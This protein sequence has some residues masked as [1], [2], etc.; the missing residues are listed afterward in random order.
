MLKGLSCCAVGWTVSDSICYLFFWVCSLTL[1]CRCTFTAAHGKEIGWKPQY[2][3]EHILE[4][5]D[6]EVELILAN[7]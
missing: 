2:A 5:A 3:P 1:E 7:L 4:D 6:A